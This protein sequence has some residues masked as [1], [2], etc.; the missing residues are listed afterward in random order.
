MNARNDSHAPQRRKTPRRDKHIGVRASS[1]PEPQ[2]ELR[3]GR[4]TRTGEMCV[5]NSYHALRQLLFYRLPLSYRGIVRFSFRRR[6]SCGFAGNSSDRFLCSYSKLNYVAAIAIE[7][8]ACVGVFYFHSQAS[9]IDPVVCETRM[10]L[11]PIWSSLAIR[12]HIYRTFGSPE[13]R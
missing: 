9:R 5:R 2:C 1:A 8:S 4:S 12:W 11:A 3:W 7:R 6:S 13:A 10:T